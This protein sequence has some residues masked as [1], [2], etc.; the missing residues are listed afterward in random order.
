MV[1]KF[2]YKAVWNEI[3]ISWNYITCFNI[4]RRLQMHKTRKSFRQNVW[5]LFLEEWRSKG[6]LPPTLCLHEVVFVEWSIFIIMITFSQLKSIYS[7]HI[8]IIV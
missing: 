7:Q 3:R 1:N 6:N 8:N 2:C 4:H 5:V